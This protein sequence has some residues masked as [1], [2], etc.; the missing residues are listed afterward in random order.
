VPPPDRAAREEILRLQ[1]SGRPH[2]EGLRLSAIAAAT[3]GYS[4]ADLAG[5]VEEAADLAIEASLA[6]GREVTITGEH[7]EAAQRAARSTTS[8]WLTTA[9][10]HAR[11]ANEGGQYDDVLAF[12]ERWSKR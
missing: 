10:N 7:L 1:L 4:G 9:R 11:Y 8:E 6:G 3:A 2:A 12:L 5:L